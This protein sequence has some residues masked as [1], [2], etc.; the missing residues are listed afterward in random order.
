[1]QRVVVQVVAKQQGR[2]GRDGQGRGVFV[3]AVIGFDDGELVAAVPVLEAGCG[4]RGGRGG[5]RGGRGGRWAM[6][7]RCHKRGRLRK[8]MDSIMNR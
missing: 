5:G 3:G 6:N 8:R 2:I 4:G 7:V 1:M